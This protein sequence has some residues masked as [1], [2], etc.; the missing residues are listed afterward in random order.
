ME[1]AQFDQSLS[2]GRLCACQSRWEDSALARVNQTPLRF[3]TPKFSIKYKISIQL[4][5]VLIGNRQKNVTFLIRNFI[6]F[7]ILLSILFQLLHFFV[8]F[9]SSC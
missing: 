4:F 7:F 5:I 3:Y 8:D 6:F 2:L 9:L 1:G